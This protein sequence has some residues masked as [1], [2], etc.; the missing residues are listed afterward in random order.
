MAEMND[1]LAARWNEPGSRPG[2]LFLGG[3]QIYADDVDENWLALCK[4]AVPMLFGTERTECLPIQGRDECFNTSA[5]R[6]SELIDDKLSLLDWVD[7]GRANFV[8][9]LGFTSLKARQ[10]LLFFTDYVCTYLLTWSPVLWDE[11]ST[12]RKNLSGFR[13]SLPPIRKLLANIPTYMM[14]DDSVPSPVQ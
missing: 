12:T 4:E 7:N 3:D 1:L 5:E 6:E 8:K 11:L 13:K 14:F 2:Q 10:H 9:S